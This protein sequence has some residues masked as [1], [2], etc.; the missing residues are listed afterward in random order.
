[1]STK[2]MIKH[3]AESERIF[4]A[5]IIDLFDQ[6]D[7]GKGSRITGFCDLRQAVIVRTIGQAY[8][9]VLDSHGGYPDAERVLFLISPT[10]WT[11]P[12]LPISA[13]LIEA[14]GEISHRDIL[15]SVLALGIK[16][17]NIGDIIKTELGHIL[18]AKHPIQQV[19]LD[20]LKRIGRQAITCREIPL[21]QVPQPIRDFR[22]IKGT[23]KSLR[24]DSVVSLCIAKSRENGKSLVESERVT[25][26]AVLRSDP[27]FMLPAHAVL[28][29][30]GFGKFIVDCDGKVS[31]KGRHFLEI[32]KLM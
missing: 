27:S 11:I 8:S 19:I 22:L 7:S 9:L 1:M 14:Y 26:D 12:P 15:G 3:F 10:E 2:D 18:F 28:S 30:R 20:E 23:V 29:I 24:L 21:S 25:V 17:E 4:A 31:A 16:R 32:R 13:I 5:H 6:V